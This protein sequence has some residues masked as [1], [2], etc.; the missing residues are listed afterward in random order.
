[1]ERCSNFTHPGKNF[2]IGFLQG[3][4]AAQLEAGRRDRTADNAEEE[5]ND[6]RRVACPHAEC[7]I[8][9]VERERTDRRYRVFYNKLHVCV[10]WWTD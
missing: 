3:K 1:M 6:L 8:V 2:L 9:T 4:D 7:R 10:N 5:D